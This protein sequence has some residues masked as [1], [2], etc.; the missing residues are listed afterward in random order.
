[1]KVKTHV[2]S[3]AMNHNETLVRAKAQPKGLRVRT[4][5]KAGEDN[6]FVKSGAMNHNETLVRDVRKVQ[7]K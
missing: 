5:I 2:K 1:M 3:G 6:C 7:P 4:G